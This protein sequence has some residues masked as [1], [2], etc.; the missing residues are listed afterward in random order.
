[1]TDIPSEA[2]V[3]VCGGGP[4]GSTVATVL[5]RR[6]LRVALF[7]R[8]RFPRFHIGESLLP[9]SLP[10]LERI[11]VLEKLRAARPTVKPGARFYHQG[12]D[13]KR[14][15]KF[16]DGIAPGHPIAF[17]VK[18]ADYDKLL[19][20]H[21]RSCGTAVFE[22]TEVKEVLF[23]AGGRAVGVRVRTKGGTATRDVAAKAVVDATGRDALLSKR[24]GG[25][26]RD[27]LLDRCGV[28]AHWSAYES[29]VGPEGGDPG[30]IVIVTTAGGWWWMIPFSDGAV[31]VGIVMPSA[32]FQSR[33][34]TS[35]AD[36]YDSLV[37]AT[38][39]VKGRLRAARRSTD[40]YAIGDYSYKTGTISGDGF[41][42]VGDAACFLDPV[43]ST[44]VLLATTSG[45]LAAETIAGCL[46]R[47]GRVD[48][49]DFR[50]YEET[51]RRGVRRYIH[52]V[53]GF[54]D[55]AFLQT[56]YTR[57]PIWAIERTI[58]SVLAGNV[59]RPGWNVRWWTLWLRFFV[60]VTRLVQRVKG[61]GEFARGTG[62]VEP[63][64]EA[65]AAA[66]RTW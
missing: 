11:G 65:L 2:D 8:E 24:V 1:M 62:L 17:Q 60:G 29:S 59:F 26:H 21:S 58:V 22:E 37:E 46:A 34:G 51:Y 31:S 39:E 23:D 53:H 61:P 47:K 41:V 20:D 38:P 13:H 30:D 66:S 19:L 5:A 48:R 57:C 44:G 4:G 25:R 43:F 63:A 54:Y 7:E 55:P 6:G 50:G 45:E 33:G 16:A 49:S 10:I 18:R 35:L 15:V 36:L 56:F 3:V 32:R 12:T 52:F 14:I 27:P 42:L 64:P 9:F 40:V 28:F